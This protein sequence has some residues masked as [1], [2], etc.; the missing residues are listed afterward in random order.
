[1]HYRLFADTGLYVS[2]LALSTMTSGG[3]GLWQAI[4]TLGTSEVER[5]GAARAPETAR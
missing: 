5:Q 4:G 3:K 1:M 2:E